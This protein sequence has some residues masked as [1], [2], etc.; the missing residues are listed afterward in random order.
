MARSD[1]KGEVW[2]PVLYVELRKTKTS[3]MAVS[4]GLLNSPLLLI[5]R[6]LIAS[7][8]DNKLIE[9]CRPLTLST[10]F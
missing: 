6:K 8:S 1:F 5:I 7:L 2:L 10:L 4:K 3:L 9:L